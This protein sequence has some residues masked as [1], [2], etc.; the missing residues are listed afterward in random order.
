[1]TTLKE[2]IE[3]FN[4]AI[5]AEA[6]IV[7]LDWC[8]GNSALLAKFAGMDAITGRVWVSRGA[9]SPAGAVILGRVPGFPLCAEEMSPGISLDLYRRRQC[10]HCNRL[11][12][13]PRMRSGCRRLKTN[14]KKYETLLL[15]RAEALRLKANPDVARAEDSE[16]RSARA[17]LAH[18]RRAARLAEYESRIVCT[19]NQGMIYKAPKSKKPTGY[20]PGRPK[21][22]APPRPPKVPGKPGRKPMHADLI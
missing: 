6:L 19:P 7:A 4:T 20:P 17:L 9:I 14:S 3:A 1:M 11:L 10:N 22:D 12:H 21:K 18:E 16:K 13:P 5:R 8:G 2:R 15:E